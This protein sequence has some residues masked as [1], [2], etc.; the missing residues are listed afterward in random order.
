MLLGC[1]V[2]LQKRNERR[3]IEKEDGRKRMIFKMVGR[4]G[5][6]GK[7]FLLFTGTRLKIFDV[8]LRDWK[9]STIKSKN[10]RTTNLSGIL[11]SISIL[12]FILFWFFLRNIAIKVIA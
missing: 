6:G 1:E 4:G 3:F 8:N 5:D 7:V 9:K 10:N 11:L 12:S 2:Q